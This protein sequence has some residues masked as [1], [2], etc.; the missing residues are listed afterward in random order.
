MKRALRQLGNGL[1]NCVCKTCSFVTLCVYYL[2]MANDA[3]DDQYVKLVKKGKGHS[4]QYKPVVPPRSELYRICSE[5]MQAT[6]AEE[7]RS[8][9]QKLLQR[10]VNMSI[11]VKMHEKLILPKAMPLPEQPR[12]IIPKMSFRHAGWSTTVEQLSYVVRLYCTS[13]PRI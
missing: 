6:A 5:Q 8:S 1:G 10:P 3:D 2:T 11:P 13:T 12:G 9:A 4:K 7:S